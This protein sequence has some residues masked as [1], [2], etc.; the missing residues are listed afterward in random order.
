MQKETNWVL[1]C[2]SNVYIYVRTILTT[3]MISSKFMI[4]FTFQGNKMEDRQD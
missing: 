3:R 2:L 1:I 4:G